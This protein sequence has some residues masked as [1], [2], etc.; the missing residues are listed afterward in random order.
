MEEYILDILVTQEEMATLDD[1]I[2][3]LWMEGGMTYTADG[4]DVYFFD[5]FMKCRKHWPEIHTEFFSGFQCP[6]CRFTTTRRNQM[7]R[8]MSR[9]HPDKATKSLEP[10]TQ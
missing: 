3:A 10:S 1:D 9:I 4:C 6:M 7:T 2:R 5:N 8:H